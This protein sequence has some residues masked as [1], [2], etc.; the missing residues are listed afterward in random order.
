MRGRG[1]AAAG[2]LKLGDKGWEVRRLKALEKKRAEQEKSIRPPSPFK[3]VFEIDFPLPGE[4][5]YIFRRW[6]IWASDWVRWNVVYWPP[7]DGFVMFLILTNCFFLA[8]ETPNLDE[9]SSLGQL[10][11]TA[12]FFYNLLFTIEAAVKWVG[13]G[14]WGKFEEVYGPQDHYRKTYVGYFCDTWNLLDFVIVLGGWFSMGAAKVSALRV[15]RVLRPL[16][17]VSHIPKLKQI[18]STFF[19]SL[20]GLF[21]VVMLLAFTLLVFGIIGLQ[22]FQGVLHQQCFRAEYCP[23]PGDP[24]TCIPLYKDSVASKT[25]ISSL[26]ETQLQAAL[27][28]DGIIACADDG[29][30][31]DGYICDYYGE[32]PDG[33]VSSFDNIGYAV[34]NCFVSITL[35]WTTLMQ[36][37]MDSYGSPYIWPFF[38]LLTFLV[39]FFALNLVL[40]VVCNAFDE[41]A[42]KQFPPGV[43]ELVLRPE[44]N[45][46]PDA[47]KKL[48][49]RLTDKKLTKVS[50]DDEDA[51]KTKKRMKN[52]QNSAM[53]RKIRRTRSRSKIGIKFV[54]KSGG[55]T[56]EQD[57]AGDI[58]VYLAQVAI[59]LTRPTHI[60]DHIRM[61]Q[62][63]HNYKIGRYDTV[64]LKKPK[65]GAIDNFKEGLEDMDYS[66]K[67]GNPINVKNI[68]LWNEETHR[69]MKYHGTQSGDVLTTQQLH[70]EDYVAWAHV[71]WPQEGWIELHKLVKMSRKNL[72][73]KNKEF[74]QT[75]KTIHLAQHEF[76]STFLSV[77]I[78]SNYDIA[79]DTTF[80]NF[81]M[82][83]IILNALTMALEWDGVDEVVLSGDLLLV[84][85]IDV[86]NYIFLVIFTVEMII[87]H[88][89]F[90]LAGYWSDS[91]N[92]F[93]GS[94]VLFS[95]SEIGIGMIVGGNTGSLS[96]LR[97][98]RL[99]RVLRVLRLLNQ[100]DSLRRQMK[101]IM[102]SVSSVIWLLFLLMLFLFTFGILGTSLFGGNQNF[103]EPGEGKDGLYGDRYGWAN[104]YYSMLT[105]FQCITGDS[106]RSVQADT[107]NSTGTVAVSIFFV[108]VM[109][110]GS[111]MLLNIFVAI[112]LTNMSEPHDKRLSDLETMM[113]WAMIEHNIF[114][115]SLDMEDEMKLNIICKLWQQRQEK[116][117]VKA[118][119]PYVKHRDKHKAM[120][121]SLGC[122]GVEHPFRKF[123]HSIVHKD[124]FVMF[125]DFSIFLNCL[126]LALEDA[127]IQKDKNATTL[128][129]IINITDWFFTVVFIMEMAL[130]VIALGFQK[131][132]YGQ[133]RDWEKCYIPPFASHKIHTGKRCRKGQFEELLMD[134]RPAI[135]QGY[136]VAKQWQYRA[137]EDA[138][139]MLKDDDYIQSVDMTSFWLQKWRQE[140]W[141]FGVDEEDPFKRGDDRQLDFENELDLTKGYIFD[142]VWTAAHQDPGNKSDRSLIIIH[143]IIESAA[144]RENGRF[145]VRFCY[146]VTDDLLE[147]DDKN[148]APKKARLLRRYWTF[149]MKKTKGWLF[150]DS[151]AQQEASKSTSSKK[152][153]SYE[154]TDQ[155]V[156]QI[157]QSIHLDN[158]CTT[159]Y[160]SD[161]WNRLDAAVVFFTILAL[162]LP[163]VRPLRALRAVR[164][165]RLAIRVPAIKVVVSTLVAAVKPA[166]FALVFCIFLF[167]ILAILGV[168]LFVGKFKQCNGA[169]GYGNAISAYTYDEEECIRLAEY[170]NWQVEWVNYAFHFDNVGDAMMTIFV[171]ASG[172][173]WHVIMYRGM[174]APQEAGGRP[175][176][177][178]GW[179]YGIYF[180]VV[181]ILAGFFSFNFVV[182]A[183]VDK[184]IEVQGEKDGTAF[185]TAAQAQWQ[186]TQ[187]V[188]DKFTLERIP[189]RPVRNQVR[190]VCYD[191][192]NWGPKNRRFD[193]II[194]VCIVLNTLFMCLSH[195]E[196]SD[197]FTSFLAAFDLVFI[198]IFTIE[199]VLKIIA[200][201]FGTYWTDNWNKFDFIVVILSYPGLF[202]G[203]GGMSTNVFRVFRIGRILRLIK[204]ARQLNLLFSTLVY[205]LPSLW[206][207]GLLLFIVYFIFA[208]VGVSL[209]G[210]IQDAGELIHPRHRNWKN[211]PNAMQLL[212][213]GSTGDSWTTPWQ[214]LMA[215][216][217]DLG[218][219]AFYNLMFF[220][221]IGLV[222][223]NL[224]I[225]V[226]L[227][228]Y[229]ANDKINKAEE[230]MLSVHRFTKLWNIADRA[231][232]GHLPV[233]QVMGLLKETP[234]P[235]GFAK[236]LKVEHEENLKKLKF[237]K[238]FEETR[239]R[240]EKMQRE[241]K[242]SGREVFIDPDLSEVTAQL[243]RYSIEC[244]YW[245]DQGV[246]VIG[247]GQIVMSFATQLLQMDVEEEKHR[248]RH[249]RWMRVHLR[250]ET[251][252]LYEALR[253]GM[254]ARSSKLGQRMLAL[255]ADPETDEE[256]EEEEIDKKQP[257]LSKFATE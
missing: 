62:F 184:F 155:E 3:H 135:R 75:V 245:K 33:K 98:F 97:A 206:N 198:V 117:R 1:G 214:G 165:L 92:S 162:I 211:W 171:I 136:E 80:G 29:M 108:L 144:D 14:F 42:Q 110:L 114:K 130:K 96:A 9:A 22:L 219:A 76:S 57:D 253:M 65:K 247:F 221:V 241:S 5:P 49:Q 32:N 176:L 45:V 225:G 142:M 7:F 83:V 148:S 38:Y 121:N 226:I 232:I 111:F 166:V 10:L 39:A 180:V 116:A 69:M 207:V 229:D 16:R 187:R 215:A 196:Q 15:L 231:T 50:D 208:V 137:M 25:F 154:E 163:D 132:P 20:E 105:L 55:N 100:F 146:D 133:T 86:V 156:L 234:W 203:S 91:W 222:M 78:K 210:D 95:I 173:S 179:F 217:G 169:D 212:Y 191:I 186:K 170:Y 246:W 128:G 197:S 223:L 188:K 202:M 41:E 101:S 81:I 140:N 174:D 193:N 152:P 19:D 254:K 104:L 34:L 230:K 157:L 143:F 151:D 139:R 11:A 192:V 8:I 36:Q 120:G 27:Q 90:G 126:F 59:E 161:N 123:I 24:S 145:E 227:D 175:V 228:T 70:E 125:I 99:F 131:E 85:V 79:V 13:L 256:D 37:I 255:E 251:D 204:K 236:P 61:K 160:W 220:V 248:S 18:V 71:Q 194:T 190:E 257:E 201:T 54:D 237:D 58:D 2:A 134:I 26:T 109:V 87:K 147:G 235:I 12:D 47:F 172:D 52:I 6:W 153:V 205:S 115:N 68:V 93:D 113:Q 244:K 56:E 233:E 35:D 103:G 213:V 30:C 40:A 189:P 200:F 252:E 64:Y 66:V 183:I 67:A 238:T 94:I 209:F 240:L 72:E 239:K 164:P 177:N 48:C 102:A 46:P 60:S 250:N 138:M 53:E 249:I 150:W 141:M 242:K 168:N 73:P 4:P 158:R 224:F 195:Y 127:E 119:H 216:S 185:A 149:D 51:E 77:F 89:G 181:M 129:R 23:I 82:S 159:A 199:C 124:W 122:L 63:F 21:Y 44:A 43:D 17:N 243:S 218:I 28:P 182:S 118:R 178:G 107:A 84:E 106:W 167:F 112:L 74:S 31:D 88:V